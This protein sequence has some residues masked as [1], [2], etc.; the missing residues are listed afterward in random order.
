MELKYRVW[1]EYEIDGKI[2]TSMESPE[3]WF[4]LTQGGKLWSYG[5]L[6]KP[7]PLGK[8]YIKAIPLLYTGLK[9]LDGEEIY[10]GDL[11][12]NESGRICEVK[13]S[14]KH[15]QWDASV[16]IIVEND[17]ASGFSPEEW[18]HAVKIIGNIYENSDLLKECND[19]GRRAGGE[20]ERGE[21]R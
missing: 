18:H 16:K 2:E 5:P 19:G 20:R 13:W 21:D 11:I 7:Q 1:C 6:Q 15:G 17:N 12:Q 3:S 9:D 14:E 8:E 4:L 10:K